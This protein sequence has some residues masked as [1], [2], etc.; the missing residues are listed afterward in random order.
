MQNRPLTYDLHT[1][2]Y[3]ECSLYR[4][5]ISVFSG[6]AIAARSNIVMLDSSYHQPL[7]SKCQRSLV[8]FLEGP[9]CRIESI[10]VFVFT[11]LPKNVSSLSL[12]QTAI[13]SLIVLNT[14]YFTLRTASVQPRFSK[15]L[16]RE[17]QRG[18]QN[19]PKWLFLRFSA[20]DSLQFTSQLTNRWHVPQFK[21]TYIK[22]KVLCRVA[23]AHLPS[24]SSKSG[25]TIKSCLEQALRTS[26]PLPVISR[27]LVANFCYQRNIFG[28]IQGAPV[29]T[30]F[31]DRKELAQ[32]RVHAGNQQGIW[33]SSEYGAYSIV[34]NGGY[35]DDD[36]MGETL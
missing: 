22:D 24:P 18:S 27:R 13:N 12:S 8:F 16:Q 20:L 2:Y 1:I 30:H 25:N 29:G 31:I 35:V 5:V 14:Q 15:G 17:D 9:R 7:T 10:D 26:P 19:V 33:G 11:P 36:D 28:E 3:V 34:L 4:D 23:I 32:A 21:L 6:L